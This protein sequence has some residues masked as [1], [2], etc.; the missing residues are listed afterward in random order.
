MEKYSSRNAFNCLGTFLTY[1]DLDKFS[2]AFGALLKDSGLVAGD[3][4]VLMMPN[5]L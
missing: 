4:I 5:I 2:T 3:K 1:N